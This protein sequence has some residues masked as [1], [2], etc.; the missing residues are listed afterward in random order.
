MINIDITERTGVVL[1]TS[2]KY[3]KEDIVVKP[4]VQDKTVTFN[5]NGLKTISPDDG[6]CGTGSVIVDVNVP[7]SGKYAN[8][9]GVS[10]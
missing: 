3:C 1:K 6:Y 4:A 2:G 5:S 7:I 10:F 9:E 8:A